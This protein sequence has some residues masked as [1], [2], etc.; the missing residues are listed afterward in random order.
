MQC[1]NFLSAL[2]ARIKSGVV[3]VVGR[4]GDG[5]VSLIVRSSDDRIAAR[6]SQDKSSKNSR[7]TLGGSPSAAKRDMAEGGGSQPEKLKEALEASYNIIERLL[8]K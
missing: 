6:P 8:V 7:R 1:D 3:V 2:L 5:K 4:S